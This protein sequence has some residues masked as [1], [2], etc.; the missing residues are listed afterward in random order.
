L[1]TAADVH[2]LLVRN[3]VSLSGWNNLEIGRSTGVVIEHCVFSRSDIVSLAT[4]GGHDRRDVV[5]RSS[6]ITDNLARKAE[7]PL[8]GHMLLENNLFFLRVPEAQ[9]SVFGSGRQ[10]LA[11]YHREHQIERAQPGRQPPVRCP[12]RQAVSS[13][14][15][16]S[17]TTGCCTNSTISLICSP[18]TLERR[19]R[20]PDRPG[21]RRL[22]RKTGPCMAC[23]QWIGDRNSTSRR[24]HVLNGK[25][26]E[27]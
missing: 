19:G 7:A 24:F 26:S 16:A 6:I 2:D 12:A 20:T 5:V 11:Q 25:T 23:S 15:T 27:P 13:R 3:C 14:P 4:G 22:R 1:L 17:S 8:V 9:R 18:R 21:P 10:M